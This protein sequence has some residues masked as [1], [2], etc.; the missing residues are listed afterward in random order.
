MRKVLNEKTLEVVA[1]EVLKSLEHPEED[2]SEL[3]K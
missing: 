1:L 2:S 3:F